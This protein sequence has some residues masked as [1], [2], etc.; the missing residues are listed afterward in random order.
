MVVSVRYCASIIVVVMSV[1]YLVMPGSAPTE[2]DCRMSEREIR[3]RLADAGVPTTAPTTK[4]AA[5]TQPAELSE[6]Q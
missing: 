6:I 5:T 1:C 3:A 4:P 2:L